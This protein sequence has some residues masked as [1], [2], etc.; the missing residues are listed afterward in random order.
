MGTVARRDVVVMGSRVRGRRGGG[1]KGRASS[2]AHVP[3]PFGLPNGGGW[4][5]MFGRQAVKATRWGRGPTVVVLHR[6]GLSL[7]PYKRKS[8]KFFFGRGTS[9]SRPLK[10]KRVEVTQLMKYWYEQPIY[11]S[12]SR[13]GTEDSRPSIWIRFIASGTILIDSLLKSFSPLLMHSRIYCFSK[14]LA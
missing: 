6:R 11:F 2:L 5:G 13:C 12:L 14:V 4:E 8:H 3:M 10:Y 9:I 1:P 7:D